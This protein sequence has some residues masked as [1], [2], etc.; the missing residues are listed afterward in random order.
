MH[1]EGFPG[2]TSVKEHTC[3]WRKLKTRVLSLGQDDALEEEMA[4]H[5]SILA[6]RIPWTEDCGLQSAGSQRVRHDRC[7]LAHMHND[8]RIL[9]NWF[10]G[11]WSFNLPAMSY[12]MCLSTWDLWHIALYIHENSWASR[13]G[14]FRK[15][16]S[17][18]RSMLIHKV[19]LRQKV[20]DV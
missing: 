10:L 13:S 2:S 16:Y 14:T 3:Q 7:D 9:S 6:R 15:V 17:R 20:D 5:S 11:H 12:D 19:L 18:F 8:T 4:T 1:N